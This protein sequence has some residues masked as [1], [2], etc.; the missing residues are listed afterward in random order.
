MNSKLT[1]KRTVHSEEDN[2]IKYIFYRNLGKAIIEFSYINKNDGK[3]IICVPC[4]TMCNIGCKFC[5]TTDFIDKIPTRNLDSLEIAEG[6]CYIYDDLKLG[7]NPKTLLVSYMGSGEPILNVDGVIGS[8]LTLRESYK[9]INIRFAVATSLPSYHFSHFFKLA[10]YI[11]NFSL[12][13]KLHVSLHYTDDG[14]RGEWMP[15]ALDIKS[16]LLAAEFYKS[17]TGNPVEIHYAL[18]GGINDTVSDAIRLSEL[19]KDKDFNVKFLFYNEKTSLDA[20]ASDLG[21]YEI[22]KSSL[23]MYNIS[24]EYYIPPGLSIGASCGAFLM[25]EYIK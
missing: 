15:K 6:V 18:I 11:K 10:G 17:S 5:G 4:Q 1:L 3:D 19:L 2:T 7:D 8:M 12:P 21:K 24:S 14:L 16:T 13:V 22:F 9:S 20:H 25:G 23:M